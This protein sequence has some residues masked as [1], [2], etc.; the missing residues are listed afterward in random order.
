MHTGLEYIKFIDFQIIRNLNQIEDVKNE[1]TSFL[2]SNYYIKWLKKYILPKIFL[3]RNRE[4]AKCTEQQEYDDNIDCI[5]NYRN[6]IDHSLLTMLQRNGE[7][8]RL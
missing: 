2:F 4:Y 6:F 8:A 3:Q 1:K 7:W 5:E